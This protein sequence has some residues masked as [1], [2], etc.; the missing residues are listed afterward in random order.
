MEGMLRRNVGGNVLSWFRK[1]KQNEEGEEGWSLDTFLRPEHRA[2]LSADE[3]CKGMFLFLF[4]YGRSLLGSDRGFVSSKMLSE[5]ASACGLRLNDAP[6]L[7]SRI[8]REVDGRPLELTCT[9]L[10]MGKEVD[11]AVVA[12]LEGVPAPRE[13][14]AMMYESFM[15]KVEA[16]LRL[17][18]WMIL[19]QKIEIE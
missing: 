17:R 5:L 13:E 12:D 1:P 7:H 2:K 9:V 8:T 10:E 14:V 15:E 16:P 3:M 11:I 6:V 18:T 4:G 19:R